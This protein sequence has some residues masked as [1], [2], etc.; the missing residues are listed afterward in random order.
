MIPLYCGFGAPHDQF[1]TCESLFLWVFDIVLV[2]MSTYSNYHHS[3]GGTKKLSYLSKTCPACPPPPPQVH[4]LK[5]ELRGIKAGLHGTTRLIQEP[6][7]LKE[8][9]KVL[10]RKHLQH[11][12]QVG[13]GHPATLAPAQFCL[14]TF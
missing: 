4:D 2:K 7:E 8:A 11:F 12:D 1:I 9:I 3:N 6:K 5:V 10:Y 13:V 14:S